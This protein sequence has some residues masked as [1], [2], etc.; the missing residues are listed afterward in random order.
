MRNGKLES[1]LAET[2]VKGNV[3]IKGLFT[4][5]ANFVSED[6]ARHN[7]KL[8]FRFGGRRAT[9]LGTILSLALVVARQRFQ[10]LYK[11]P[12]SFDRST[13]LF[14]DQK[15]L[16]PWRYSNPGSSVLLKTRFVSQC[17]KQYKNLTP[18]RDSKPFIFCSDGGDDAHYTTPPG[19]R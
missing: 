11:Y 12:L 10:R 19:R 15:N 6:V 17:I 3:P 9:Q 18:W 8:S 5:N 1:T 13:A 16:T 2:Q 14:L 4:R 7:W